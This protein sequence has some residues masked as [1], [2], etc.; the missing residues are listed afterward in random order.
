MK[1]SLSLRRVL[2]AQLW[3]MNVGEMPGREILPVGQA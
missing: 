1:I 3:K 2:A